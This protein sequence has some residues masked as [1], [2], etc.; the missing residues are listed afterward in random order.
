MIDRNFIEN[1]F[2]VNSNEEFRLG[3][4]F[5]SI[6]HRLSRRNE[7]SIDRQSNAKKKRKRGKETKEAECIDVS[8]EKCFS[9][10]D[11]LDLTMKSKSIR[12]SER[13]RISKSTIDE[14]IFSN[15]KKREMQTDSECE[16]DVSS[17]AD[18]STTT[19]TVLQST[20]N[21]EHLL[22]RIDSLTQENRVL[23]MELETYKLRLKASQ[24]EIKQLKQFDIEFSFY[25]LND[26]NSFVEF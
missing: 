22:K 8:N 9:I 10:E 3:L 18:C 15:R 6:F 11:R 16:S 14:K 7:S 13:K 4:F 23:K 24:Q 20:F 2:F 5:L 21:R 26:K 17:I 25:R 12:K 1:D 19:T